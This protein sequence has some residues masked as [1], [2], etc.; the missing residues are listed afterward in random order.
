M[1][2]NV[3]LVEDD[4]VDELY[5][6]ALTQNSWQLR[7]GRFTIVER[8]SRT[9]SDARVAVHSHRT[10]HQ[11]L[12]EQS[13]TMSPLE[14]SSPLI[15]VLTTAIVSPEIMRQ[16]AEMAMR[17]TRPCV[18]SSGD[19]TIGA[20]LPETPSHIDDIIVSLDA[21]PADEVDLVV[22]PCRIVRRLWDLLDVIDTAI[23]WD[24]SLVA[25]RVANSAAVHPTAVIDESKGPVLIDDEAEIG[26]MA[27]VQGPCSVG[28]HAVVKP[29]AHVTHSV[30][31]P[32]CKVGGEVSVTIFHGY[33]NK[34]HYGFLGHS[35]IGEWVNLGAGTTSSNLKN[36]YH[37]VRPTMPWGREDSGRLFLG[38]LIGD[39]TRT[40]IGTLLPTGGVYGVCSHV[41]G[42]G[43]ASSHVRSFIWSDKVPYERDRALATCRAMMQRRDREL[44]DLHIEILDDVR[45]RDV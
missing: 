1:R 3:I 23:N 40:A 11:R 8:W 13:F 19:A 25:Q 2:V 33:S 31:G 17:A 42:S 4:A 39:F 14:A 15:V 16:L 41:I 12:F 18:I 30:I 28:A 5:P 7:A 43:L 35:V 20:I 29:L 36:T 10:L 22:V 24:S 21:V 44:T 6:L 26:P 45:G 37:D 9:L 32:Y 34:Q 27:V 38:S